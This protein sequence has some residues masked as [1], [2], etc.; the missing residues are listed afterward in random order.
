MGGECALTKLAHYFN[1]HGPN[2]IA[3]AAELTLNGWDTGKS[4]DS[5]PAPYVQGEVVSR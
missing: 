2:E 4:L 5:L 1:S 3:C